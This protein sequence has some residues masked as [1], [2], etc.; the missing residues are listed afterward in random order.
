MHR[1]NKLDF[2]IHRKPTPTDILIHNTSCRP[3]QHGLA[4]TTYL[5]DRLHT[6]V[7]QNTLHEQNFSHENNSHKQPIQTYIYS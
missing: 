1:K 5:M 6:N 2:T 4:S 7:Y 3:D